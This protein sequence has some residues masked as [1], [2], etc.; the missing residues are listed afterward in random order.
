[1]GIVCRVLG[2]T[3]AQIGALRATPSLASGLVIAAL[4]DHASYMARFDGAL[5]RVPPEHRAEFEARRAELEAQSRAAIEASPLAKQIAE[6]RE[7][8]AVLGSIEQALDLE[9]SWHILHYSYTG[10]M[11]PTGTPGDLLMTGE[12]L[13]E[14]VGYGPPRLHGPA[15][16]RNFSRFLEAQDL[17]RLQARVDLKKMDATG[18]Y[19]VP[20]GP[21]SPAEYEKELRE[22]VGYYFGRLRAYVRGMADKGNGLLTWMS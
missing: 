16:T 2:V 20:M 22:V 11:H 19:G 12:E 14:D 6:A 4:G 5:Q 21:G 8:I 13:G 1:M 17:K 10:S 15:A 3:P 18:V 7:R 9:K